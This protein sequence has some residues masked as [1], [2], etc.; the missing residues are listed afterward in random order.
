[1]LPNMFEICTYQLLQN[2]KDTRTTTQQE[3]EKKKNGVGGGALTI[4]LNFWWWYAWTIDLMMDF[5]NL[6]VANSTNAI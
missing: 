4:I 3:G 1:M 6:N 5:D 2:R